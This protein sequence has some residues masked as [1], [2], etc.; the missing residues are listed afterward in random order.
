MVASVRSMRQELGREREPFEIHVIS[1]DGYSVDGCRRLE[2]LGVTDVIIGFRD[3]YQP[4]PDTETLPVKF[5][6]I[7]RFG[8]SVI[9]GVRG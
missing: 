5:D 2:E 1:I 4:G 7:A 3:A 6:A 8:D 9:A